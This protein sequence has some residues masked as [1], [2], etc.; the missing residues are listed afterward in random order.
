M[1]RA[2]R[3]YR[4]RSCRP[5]LTPLLLCGAALWAGC[6]AAYGTFPSLEP[7]LGRPL[8]LAAALTGAA[9]AAF[10]L[11]R[12]RPA[13]LL[14]AAMLPL[15][16]ALGWGAAASLQD[17]AAIAA[18]APGGPIALELLEDSSDSGF[19]E[20]ALALARWEDGATLAVSARLPP[21]TPFF[22]GQRI[23]CRGTFEPLDPENGGF[24]WTKGAGGTL[25]AD[26]WKEAPSPLEALV[27]LRKGAI[28]A[29]GAR[30]DEAAAVLQ[31]VICGY[32]RDVRGSDTYRAYQ[33]CGLAHLIAVSGAHLVIVTGLFGALL[34]A[35]GCPRRLAVA[36][37][38]AVMGGYLL[39]SAVPLSALRATV[40]SSVG[41][42]SLFGRRRPSSLNG[43]GAAM[44]LTVLANPAASVSASFTLSALSTAGIV[45]F[46][47]LMQEWFSAG[48]LGRVPLVADGLSLTLASSLLVQLYGCS[49]FSLLPLA[50]PVANIASA[51]FF[52]P[53]CGLGL[54]GA[55]ADI[56]SLPGAGLL[57]AAAHGIAAGLNGLVGVLAGLPFAA[58]PFTCSSLFA[59]GAS[60]AAAALLWAAWPSGR[61]AA[62]VAAL[63]LLLAAACWLLPFP[64]D[65]IVMLDVGQGDAFL[66]QSR[67]RSLLIDTGNKD[68][69]LLQGLAAHG[70]ASLDAVLVTHG[71][72]DH[73]G[74]LDAL[75]SAV[76]VDTALLAA[77]TWRCG[78][79]NAR[80][81]LQEAGRCARTL[82]PL[83]KGDRLRWGAFTATVLHPDRF[84]DQGGNGDSLCL[85]LEYDGDGDGAADATALF[86]GDA[87][88]DQLESMIAEYGL[89]DVDILKVG[90]HGSKNALGPEAMEAL[91]PRIALIG[92]GSN[93]RYGHPH[94][95]ILALLEEAGTRVL[96]TDEDGEVACSLTPGG[97]EVRTMA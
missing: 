26:T 87:E 58:V 67:G 69:R 52:A 36:I 6:A 81:L 12:R 75:E 85:W 40:M 30:G 71:D 35:L 90:H 34:K 78:D 59:L 39:F 70:I 31:A 63:G 19:G 9:G 38:A 20:N 23:V 97:I 42:F 4:H 37:L 8:A 11:M 80:G 46:A 44:A 73:C 56:L 83:A 22:Y 54:L 64:G 50:S 55:G 62:P 89:H 51:P 82:Q 16:A 53:L 15:G 41:I 60:G 43:L 13:F 3:D 17:Q 47:P 14:A 94:P 25:H 18:E 79:D 28:G 5:A 93:N 74:S 7:G 65:R 76:Q 32:R 86:T 95:G 24:A 57:L 45:L 84:Q 77:D 10:V 49:L 68:T 91:S 33:T 61:R 21:G 2:E 96:R 1:S 92:V 29:L 66:I 48:I 72:D 27:A 88:K